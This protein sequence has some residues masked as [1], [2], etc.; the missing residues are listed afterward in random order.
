MKKTIVKENDINE[1]KRKLSSEIREALDIYH[2]ETQAHIDA[3]NK[4][5]EEEIKRYIGSLTEEYQNRVSGVVEQFLGLN[6]KIDTINEK[7]DTHKEMI[8]TLMEDVTVLKDDVAEI[9]VELKNKPDTNE[10]AQL[11]LRVSMLERVS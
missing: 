3:L 7:L 9:K 5:T 1:S 11:S 4:K 6:D 2:I 10:V 8:G